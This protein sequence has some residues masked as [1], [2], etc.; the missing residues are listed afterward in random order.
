M[1]I[2]DVKYA[3]NVC[4]WADVV[5]QLE[6]HRAIGKT[7]LVKQ[8]CK[9]WVDPFTGDKELDLFVLYCA[10]QEITDLSGFPIKVWLKSGRPVV[11]GI[12]EEG[13][14]VTGWATPSWWFRLAE[15]EDEKDLA[16]ME[17]MK[18]KG[19]TEEELQLF[20]NRPKRVLFVDEFRRAAREVMQAMYPLILDKMLHTHE[21]PR[22][23]R[24]ITADNPS[25]AYDVRMPDHAMMSRFCHIKVETN[26]GSW[27]S[28]A[29]ETGVADRLRNFLTANPTFLN[30]LPKD[31]DKE[32]QSYEPLAN[33][34]GWDMVDRVM[35]HG[36]RGLTDMPPD[37]STMIQKQIV[38]GIVGFGACE[39]FFAF[40]DDCLSFEDVLKGTIKDKSGKKVSFKE[41]I[42]TKSTDVD[43]N[44]L[45]EKLMIEVSAIMKGRKYDE[46][47]AKRLKLFLVDMES[48]ERATAILQGIFLQKNSKQLDEKW[49]AELLKGTE[50]R[51]ILAHLMKKTNK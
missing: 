39:H 7:S 13:Q 44:K 6:G 9:K 22:G 51:E 42:A 35:K 36:H 50:L 27:H 37:Y 31:L 14:I 32:A 10:T 11:D 20:W 2:N 40:A 47:E 33:P 1:F 26:I 8:V 28:Y 15:G 29:V 18:A 34:R 46:D 3:V 49:T 30:N 25:G 16:I 4:L 21:L 17:Q 19:A 41:Y 45:L 48:K 12:Q 5:P 38:N 43:K 24:I 23:T